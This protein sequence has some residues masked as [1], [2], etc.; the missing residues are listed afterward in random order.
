MKYKK[1]LPGIIKVLKLFS[2]NNLNYLLFKCDHI[3]NGQ[4][5]NLDILFETADD[6]KKARELLY[7]QGFRMRLSEKVEKYKEML[8]GFIDNTMYSIHLHREIAWHG[9]KVLNKLPVFKRAIALNDLIKV[10]SLEDCILIHSGHVLFENFVITDKENFYLD[11][12]KKADNDYINKQLS[13]NRWKKGFNRI[14]ID[15]T[16]LRLSEIITF[17]SE[18]LIHE[19][20]VSL[21][22][23]KKMAKTIFRKLSLNRNGCMISFIGVNGS[24]KSTLT[25]ELSENYKQTLKHLGK[26]FF[27]YY[28][29]WKPKFF[30]TKMLSKRNENNH[31]FRKTVIKETRNRSFSLVQELSYLYQWFELYYRYL[32]EVR[33]K[34]KKNYV[35]ITDRYPYDLYGQHP[36]ASKSLVLPLLLYLFPKP[37]F[38]YVLDAE[39]KQLTNRDKTDKTKGDILP[40]KRAVF[41]LTYL[42]IQRNNYIRL[43]T[44]FGWT[45]F[46]TSRSSVKKIVHS[47]I[48]DTWGKLL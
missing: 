20:L 30:L 19:P 1:T 28:F 18:K 9:I 14:I 15:R 45:I 29:G 44:V 32:S 31:S 6:F 36:S 8:S 46:N 48:K 33:P 16:N 27:I 22:L 2:S 5:K 12:F 35:I 38:T 21:Y 41:P 42:K 40:L 10:P 25:R 17:W 7:N 34:L 43:G 47:V 39:L 26:N 3:F 23:I 24:G 13:W 11:Q 4:N 37:D